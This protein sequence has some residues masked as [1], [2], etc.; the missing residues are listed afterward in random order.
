MSVQRYHVDNGRFADHGFCKAV[1][2]SNQ[3]ITFCGVG[4]HHQNTITERHIKELTLV[5]RT[6][7]LNAKRYWSEIISTML[8]TC[9]HTVANRR[10]NKLT[11]NAN[12]K[13]SEEIFCGTASVLDPKHLHI[14]GRPIYVLD[15]KLQPGF[16]GITKGE[17]R[18]RVGI[19]IM[20]SPVHVGNLVLGLNPKS[21]LVSP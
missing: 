11:F 6:L 13:T 10:H 14:W 20:Y 15:S 17:P 19:Y 4:S 5:S 18:S 12:G 1:E 9:A 21:G 7:L 2:A 8:C 16:A 3:R